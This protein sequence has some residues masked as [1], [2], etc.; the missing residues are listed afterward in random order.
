MFGR[1]KLLIATRICKQ[2]LS[3]FDKKDCSMILSIIIIYHMLGN[4][5]SQ[6]SLTTEHIDFFIVANI[7]LIA[8]SPN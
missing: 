2:A 4:Q 7:V 8:M 1:V 6:Y 3:K 5:F